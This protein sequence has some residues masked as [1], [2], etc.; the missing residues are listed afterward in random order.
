MF[1][2]FALTNQSPGPQ[3]RFSIQSTDATCWSLRQAPLT[4][5]RLPTWLPL[6]EIC[7]IGLSSSL[8]LLHHMTEIDNPPLLSSRSLAR[9]HLKPN[10]I[11]LTFTSFPRLGVLGQFTEP[12]ADP[13]K[14]V[15]SHSLFL[16][17]EITNPHPRFPSVRLFRMVFSPCS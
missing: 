5:A 3:F 15:S 7:V 4:Q 8:W 6:K 16:P 9:Q 1:S 17:E 14:A 10:E 2:F 11:P 12:Y 13:A